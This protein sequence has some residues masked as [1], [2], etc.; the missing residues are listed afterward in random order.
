MDD[1]KIRL[2]KL[3]GLYRLIRDLLASKKDVK[4]E[5][6]IYQDLAAYLDD[7]NK[8]AREVGL[9]IEPFD[10]VRIRHGEVILRE[11]LA[12]IDIA[13]LMVRKYIQGLQ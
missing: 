6:Q 7:F 13:E 10:I 4:K 11:L 1:E 8:W 9:Q 3:Q 5:A 12:D 2:Q